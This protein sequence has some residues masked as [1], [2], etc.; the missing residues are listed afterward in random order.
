MCQVEDDYHQEYKQYI[1][2]TEEWYE[3]KLCGVHSYD[4]TN[5]QHQVANN[6]STGTG[7]VK[8]NIPSIANADIYP[9]RLVDRYRLKEGAVRA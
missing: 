5:I 9:P 2:L 1:N 3:N 7:R 8:K 6:E 4:S